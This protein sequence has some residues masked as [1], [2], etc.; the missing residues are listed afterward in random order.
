MIPL[1]LAVNTYTR[2]KRKLQAQCKVRD[3]QR[4]VSAL[5]PLDAYRASMSIYIRYQSR[6]LD[7]SDISDLL[8]TKGQILTS[9]SGLVSAVWFCEIDPVSV[10]GRT[11][12]SRL[13]WNIKRG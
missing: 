7:L 12:G 6:E 2:T 10:L 11:G 8:V 5:F 13:S 1:S 9:L 3:R 4:L